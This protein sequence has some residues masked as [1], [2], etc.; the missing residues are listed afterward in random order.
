MS[1]PLLRIRLFGP[2]AIGW[3]D[4]DDIDIRSAKQMALIAL[5]ATA[6]DGKRT[7]SWLDDMLWSNAGGDGKRSNLRQALSKVRRAIGPEYNSIFTGGYDSVRLMPDR[8]TLVGDPADGEF[9]EGLD[10][11]D[12][13]FNAWLREQRQAFEPSAAGADEAP[14][15]RPGHYHP[16]P[17]TFASARQTGFQVPP[18]VPIA[19]V[20]AVIPFTGVD[21]SG[22]AKEMGD[23]VAQV[24]T[25]ALSRSPLVHMISHL[26]SRDVRL[27]TA[28]L[29]EVRS[30]I[31]ADYLV[32]GQMRVLGEEYRLD[33]D[34]IDASSGLQR[35][36]KYY[37]GRRSDFFAGED[38]VV[39][40]VSSDVVRS[41][42][43]DAINPVAT[44]PL[45]TLQCHTLLMASIALMHKQQLGYFARARTCLEELAHRAPS[46]SIVHAW[47]A[48]WY[49]LSINQGWSSDLER[50]ATTAREHARRALEANPACS[51]SLAIDGLVHHY[52]YKIDHAFAQYEEALA[53]D[54]NNALA[55]LL[56]G[57]LH[58]FI[59]EGALAVQNTEKARA[60]SPLDPQRYY[61]DSLAAT[62]HLAN[63][64]YETALS[65][66]DQSLTANRRHTSTLRVRTIAL[67]MMGREDEAREAAN[68]LLAREP[69]LTVEAYTRTHPAKN[70]R[71]GKD[72]ARALKHAGVPTD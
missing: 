36:S 69:N 60:L 63:Q 45:P 44:R 70:Y 31:N 59:D 28:G 71:T 57:I 50:D 22:M 18:T 3:V 61:Y 43:A 9:L 32:S 11:P 21:E 26:S 65:L 15:G 41:L 2:F 25:S 72:W 38:E 56:K 46:H 66:A 30:L 23:A 6:P 54:P 14:A 37:R 67:Q 12:E 39:S 7:R 48:K 20:V 27:Q 33:V 4:G 29:S 17:T 68:E 47:L 53:L 52:A 10:I 35:W 5:L 16:V 51:L 8:M 19:P 62:A 42:L 13:G 64:D 1:Q 40:A 49:V 24:V 58:A 55:W 34:F